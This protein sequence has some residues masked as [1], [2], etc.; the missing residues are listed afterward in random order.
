MFDKIK[1]KLHSIK[2]R[3][4]EENAGKTFDI[5]LFSKVEDIPFDHWN[6]VLDNKKVLLS[7]PYLASLE[8]KPTRNMRFHYAIIYKEIQPVAILYFQEFDFALKDMSKNVNVSVIES[9]VK[10]LKKLSGI[11]VKDD[12][13]ISARLLAFGNTFATGEFGFQCV[14][15]F[16]GEELSEA[17]AQTTD[18]IIK[19]DRKKGKVNAIL[20]KD[21]YRTRDKQ[22]KAIKDNGY[23]IFNV[24]PSME[25]NIDANW[26]TFDDYLAAFSS[27]Y[28]V[29]AK[30][31][32]KKGV[33]LVHKELS[34]DE[35][36][37]HYESI[38]KLYKNVEERADFQLVTVSDNYFFDLKVALE[39]K[40]IFKAFFLDNEMVAF[41]TLFHGNDYLDANFI[42]MNYDYNLENCIYQNILY[43]DVKIAI[44]KRVSVL[45]YGRT[46]LE[47]KSTLG[48]EPHDM[49]L[50]VKHTNRITN[51]I[52][53]TIMANLKQQEWIQRRPFKEVEE[54]E[55]E[56]AKK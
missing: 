31:A 37:E 32:L 28:R 13:G 2:T 30:S 17:I 47:I 7:I 38:Q 36:M 48:A 10:G 20:L 53:G 21:F 51:S 9:I 12:E 4:S 16:S 46:A 33:R 56:L 18:K 19:S 55:E 14:D 27:K 50:F 5:A 35:I 29:R 42:G 44:E 26:K 3:C 23:H 15:N 52:L 34:A 22:L 8:I 25:L 24:Q 1:K 6:K 41:S 45:Y 40:F 11:S 39:D 54:K 43:D 49:Y